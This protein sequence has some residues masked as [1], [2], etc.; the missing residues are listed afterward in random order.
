MTV[1]IA[2]EDQEI[3]ERIKS[4]LL[5]SVVFLDA[6]G[7]TQRIFNLAVGPGPMPVLLLIPLIRDY[8]GIA[9]PQPT[10]NPHKNTKTGTWCI[11]TGDNDRMEATFVRVCDAPMDQF[12]EILPFG[13]ENMQ[14]AMV[15]ADSVRIRKDSKPVPVEAP[16]LTPHQ[17]RIEIN[18]PAAASNSPTGPTLADLIHSVD[19]EEVH[20][21]QPPKP[22]DRCWV[23]P[24]DGGIVDGEFRGV[25]HRDGKVIVVINGELRKFSAD[26][27]EFTPAEVAGVDE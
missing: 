6:Y 7:R 9:L 26:E 20:E 2:P 17:P 8:S 13:D 18:E 27:V 16:P 1:I 14:P 21:E 12:V 22:G 3:I 11:V 5:T 4:D 19:E 10:P 24:D 23:A 15:P 25:D